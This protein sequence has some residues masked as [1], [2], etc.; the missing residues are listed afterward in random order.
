MLCKKDQGRFYPSGKEASFRDG[1]E[2][3]RDQ[4]W[5]KGEHL[6]KSTKTKYHQK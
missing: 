3:L 6:D 5:D 2:L 4:Q 1:I